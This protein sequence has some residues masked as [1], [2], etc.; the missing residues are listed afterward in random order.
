MQTATLDPSLLVY[1]EARTE[2]TKQLCQFIVPAILK[3]SIALLDR[4]KEL[5]AGEPKK[6]LYQFQVLLNEIPDWN[7]DKCLTEIN[8]LEQAINCE[9]LDD[10]ITAVFIAHTKILSSINVNSTKDN[11]RIKIPDI[12][13]FLYKVLIEV[14]KLYWKSTYLFRDDV[15]NIEKQ[16]NYKQIENLINDGIQQA[17]RTMV[18]VRTILKNCISQNM[19]TDTHDNEE[20][21]LKETVEELKEDTSTLNDTSNNI[22]T[23]LIKENDLLIP[24]IPTHDEDRNSITHEPID[25]TVEPTILKIDEDEH[26]N[27][28]EF[29]EYSSVFHEEDSDMKQYDED[30]E[31]VGHQLEIL[32]EPATL[33]DEF[34]DLMDGSKSPVE[35]ELN[36]NDFD[37]F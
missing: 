6:I 20:E 19:N 1:S 4:A 2:Y 30:D 34:D 11:V 5:T 7:K 26:K 14:S 25:N 28:V 37:T 32:D 10:L 36:E 12:Q 35:S 17:I 31:S 23:T 13:M 33:I 24:I 8:K 22:N 15:S 16:Q 21:P 29:A 27:K 18:P 9:Y 3:F